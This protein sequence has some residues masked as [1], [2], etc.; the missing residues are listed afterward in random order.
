MNSIKH[1]I[2][3][4]SDF[5]Y[6]NMGGVEEHIF[7]LSQC[8]LERGHK[9]IVLTHS[10]GDRIGIRYM[11][12]GL[13]V[14]YIPVKVFY[15][16][17]V[18]PTMICSIPLIR[19]IYLREEI[20]IVHGHSAFSALAHEG[21]L[22][23]RLMG[24]K[25]IFTDHSLFGF[26]DA[27]AILT[28]K[29]LEISLAD[30]NHC[31]CVS[32]TGK[33]NTVLR[34]K[35]LKEK[36]SVIPN[37]VDTT[38][39]MPDIN[40]RDDNFITIVIVSRLVYRKG[41]DLL[42]RII[43][44]LC[45]RYQDVQFLIAGDGPKRWLIEEVR[46]RNL[47]QHRVTLLGSLKHSQIRHVLNKGHIFLNTS[48]TEAY[49]MAIVEAASCGLQVVSTK[50][51]GIPEVL[52]PDLIYLVEP[53][54]PALIE[55]LESAIT[56]YKEGNI[57]CPMEMHKKISLFY[58]WFNITKRTEVVYNLVKQESNKNLGQQLVSYIQSGVLPYLLVISLCYIILQ[59][60]EILVPRKYIDVTKE[61]TETD[62]I[63]PQE[64]IKE[65]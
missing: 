25:T 47:L 48:L 5:F 43:P 28:N 4:V 17:C 13:K 45:S 23:G 20:Q 29:F 46:E 50:V 33:E 2:C 40:K 26:A 51:G 24:L 22:I 60:L 41:V 38:L 8:L 16:Q 1:K 27:S 21:M 6:P 39:F 63:N 9:V 37:A 62:V 53:T 19:Y 15:N 12:N 7:N 61:Y 35:V 10:Y 34:A 18:L 31:I 64:K 52:P 14:Y 32:H 36:V 3:M 55:G 42:A 49:C 56:D 59:I 54:V 11:T 44:N 65:N 57:K 30:C 58:N